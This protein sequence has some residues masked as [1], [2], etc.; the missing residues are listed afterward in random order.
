MTV[1]IGVVAVLILLSLLVGGLLG[2]LVAIGK[3]EEFGLIK[4]V[5]GDEK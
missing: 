1:S 2:I 5:S 3:M 4:I